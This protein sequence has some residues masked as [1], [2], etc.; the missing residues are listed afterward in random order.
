LT[1]KK[2]LHDRSDFGD[3]ITI[4]ANDVGISEALVEKDY[5]VTHTLWSLVQAG[6]TV[7][8]KGGTSLSKGY[9]VIER[10]SEDIDAKLEADGLPAVTSWKSSSKGA[11]RSRS[12]FFDALEARID[13]PG[14]RV[15]RLQ[16]SDD[17]T[18]RNIVFKVDYEGQFQREL[19]EDMRPFV[20]LEVGSARVNPGE[21]RP[22]T[23]WIHEFAY[24][25]A[26]EVAAE[27]V[28]NRS[29][30]HCVFPKITL[31]EK[32]EAIGRCFEQGKSAPAF[33]RHYEDSAKILMTLEE[34]GVE[35][36]NLLQELKDSGDVKRWP[37]ADDPAFSFEAD[38]DR[39]AQLQLSWQ[40][41]ERLYWGERIELLACA[42]MIRDFLQKVQE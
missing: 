36:K 37:T 29:V 12:A 15:S 6:L 28:D 23:S 19:P 41:I 22:I 26:P 3:L 24:R 31:L 11:V 16:T 17:P 13:V 40:A 33:V 14:A 38:S 42:T 10:F 21:R 18:F 27:C 39:W 30:I 25:N 7:L 8:F 9:G 20:Q 34:T 1:A 32:I 35:M 5:W 4:V 2:F